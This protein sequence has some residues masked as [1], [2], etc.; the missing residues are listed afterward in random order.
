MDAYW[1]ANIFWNTFFLLSD[2]LLILCTLCRERSEEMLH[3]FLKSSKDNLTREAQNKYIIHS[4]MLLTYLRLGP[5]WCQLVQST[6]AYK[7]N[8]KLTFIN[9]QE[10]VRCGA[11]AFSGAHLDCFPVTAVCSNCSSPVNHLNLLYQGWPTGTQRSRAAMLCISILC[12]LQQL[13]YNSNTYSKTVF[14]LHS[15]T[16]QLR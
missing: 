10:A 2:F 1:R 14:E 6:D 7:H 8:L 4:C 16:A 15:Y 9:T 13:L 12:W 5:C 3:K 11:I